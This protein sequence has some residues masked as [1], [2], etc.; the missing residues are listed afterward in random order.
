LRRGG[1]RWVEYDRLASAVSSGN[2][3]AVEAITVVYLEQRRAVCMK[4]QL[5]DLR[6]FKWLPRIWI[7]CA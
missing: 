4:F 3:A 6:R 7:E 5:H 2:C 1:C